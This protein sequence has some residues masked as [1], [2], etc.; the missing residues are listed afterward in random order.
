MNKNK[1]VFF[2]DLG[3]YPYKKTWEYQETLLNRIVAQKK[4]KQ[5][6]NENLLTSNYFLYVE[7]PPVYTLGRSG[8]INNL[9]INNQQL[10][11]KDIEFVRTN[12]GGDITF[13]GK[14][15]IVGYPILDLENFW[16]DI[17]K[18]LRNLEEM[19][20]LTLKEYGIKGERSKGETGVWIDCNT[21]FVRKICA[22]GV[23]SSRWVTMHG[24][25]FNINTNLKYFDYIIP[26]GITGKAITSL[27]KELKKT[28]PMSEV[29][30]KLN[31]YFENLF[32][33]E[34][35]RKWK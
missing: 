16:K 19:V 6:K 30:K 17:H 33:I 18:Y 15:Q 23:R 7:H 10:K 25:A 21:P 24:F 27:Q 5:K 29:K 4:E 31:K 32:N 13:H 12:R 35:V 1:K 14:G 28:I 11:Q 9:L 3:N 8:N 22:I 20:I 2:K 26:C 34:L